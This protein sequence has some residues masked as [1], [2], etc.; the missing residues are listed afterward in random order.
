[1]ITIDLE[2]G[3]SDWF[4]YRKGIPSASRFKDVMAKG[5]TGNT[6]RKYLYEKVAEVLTG[7]MPES[8][9]NEHMLRGIEQEPDAR[10]LY[11]FTQDVTVVQTGLGMLDDKSACASPDGLI[12]NDGGLE[13]KS[14]IPTV[15]IETIIKGKMP[16]QHMAQVQGNL[17]IFDREWWDF[18]SYCP[19][20][21]DN[22]LFIARVYR[23]EDYIKNLESEVTRFN[24]DVFDIVNKVKQSGL[25]NSNP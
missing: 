4:E 2:Q 13:I 18:V 15:H 17:W 24:D 14:V 10:A 1:M 23:D 7:K 20:I 25:T 6:R 11:E 3:S 5:P 12:N 21:L 8:Y 9:Q 19:D 16:P 22:Q